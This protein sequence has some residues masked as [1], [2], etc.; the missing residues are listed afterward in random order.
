M[1]AQHIITQPV[2]EALFEGYLRAQQT[3][4]P[5]PCRPCWNTWSRAATPRRIP[6]PLQKFYESV[7]LSGRRA[8][9]TPKAK[10]IIIELYDKF[11]KAAFPED[12]GTAR[13]R[14]HTPVEVV[15]FPS[16]I[17]WTA[18]CAASSGGTDEDNVHILDPFTGSACCKADSSAGRPGP[19]NRHELRT[20][21]RLVL[22][23]TSPPST[24][25]TPPDATPDPDDGV[26]TE[27]VR[28]LRGIVLTGLP[29]G[30]KRSGGCCSPR[31]FPR[32][33][34]GRPPEESPVRRDHRQPAA[35]IGQKSA[36]DNAQNRNTPG[37]TSASPIPMLPPPPRV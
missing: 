7:A 21:T 8:S 37:S 16:C 25:R 23:P 10:R 17:R 14:L 6:I 27:Q 12:G 19:R 32:T 20:P 4:S 33:R 24:S 11:F 35:S 30:R 13:H 3:R 26:E 9:T 5:R 28:A 2:F 34:P 1:L 31:C 36:N 29:V 22:L 18:Y 15:G